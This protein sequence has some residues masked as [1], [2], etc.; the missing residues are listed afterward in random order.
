VEV[1]SQG[2]EVSETFTDGGGGYRLYGVP[3]DAEFSISRDG[4]V[5]VKT[6]HTIADH[7][8]LDFELQLVEPRPQL[9]GTYT[10]TIAIDGP[11]GN[12]RPLPEALQQ[13]TYTATIEQSGARLDVTL[14]GAQFAIDAHGHGN[15]F[16]G[17]VEPD[18]VNFTLSNGDIYYYYFYSYFFK[19]HPDIAERLPDQS[20]LVVRGTARTAITPAGM[21]GTLHGG[22]VHYGAQFPSAHY[23]ASCDGPPYTFSLTR[24][25]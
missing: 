9:A 12:S 19:A 24:M 6:Q 20:V 25:N 13:R 23:I 2:R 4:Y 21:S 1:G 10:L 22:V 8:A 11:C 18:G 7:A 16:Q 17:R 3:P 14:S 15:R 5:P